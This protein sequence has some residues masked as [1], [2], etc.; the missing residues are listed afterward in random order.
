[1]AERTVERVDPGSIA[2][3]GSLEMTPPPSSPHCTVTIPHGDRG[4][5]VLPPHPLRWLFLQPGDR[6]TPRAP[7]NSLPQDSASA[8]GGTRSGQLSP[9]WLL[10]SS[11]SLAR[12]GKMDGRGK[13]P[14]GSELSLEHT[15]QTTGTGSIAHAKEA[16]G[17]WNKV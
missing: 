17:N 8:A 5:E 6:Q 7:E 15:D 4:R 9:S 11:P 12:T 13:K 2:P 1:M 16:N 14:K 3:E 10:P